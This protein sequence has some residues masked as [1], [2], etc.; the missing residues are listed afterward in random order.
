[1]KGPRPPT[2]NIYERL[3]V[4]CPREYLTAQVSG[5]TGILIG[6]LNPDWGCPAPPCI[7]LNALEW[8]PPSTQ[9]PAPILGSCFT[10]QFGFLAWAPRPAVFSQVASWLQRWDKGA[11]SFSSVS[12]LEPCEL[13]SPGQGSLTRLGNRAPLTHIALYQAFMGTL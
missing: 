1:M 2:R 5:P 6:P 4:I 11:R 7:S 3:D 8:P 9:L 13:P 10:L 12:L